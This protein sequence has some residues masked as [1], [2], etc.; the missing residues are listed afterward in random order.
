MWDLPE[1][2][3]R[4]FPSLLALPN[5][6]FEG[7]LV[8]LL[9]L[10][11]VKAL[12]GKLVHSQLGLLL[13]VQDLSG[14]PSIEYSPLYHLAIVILVLVD[15]DWNMFDLCVWVVTYI[16]VGYLRR[17]LHFLKSE[18]ETASTN[19]NYDPRVLKL[20]EFSK[21]WGLL[22][23]WL[24]LVGIVAVQWLFG[25][26]GLR[27][28]TLLLFPLMM[29]TVEGG[30][31][32]LASSAVLQDVL[33][34]FNQNINEIQPTYKIDLAEKIATS[35]VRVWHY[36][37]ISRMFLRVFIR[38]VSIIEYVWVYSVVIAGLASLKNLIVSINKYRSY[39][40]LMRKFDRIFSRTTSAPDQNCTICLTE[41]LNCRQLAVCGHL[42]HYRCL[43]HW[44]QTK[45]ECPICRAPIPLA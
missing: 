29:V 21:Q 16:G 19:V 11:A 8:L 6:T 13:P 41:L 42:F 26:S 39:S 1:E 24:G 4:R 15:I 5:V 30:L 43:F 14:S 25:L 3:A 45:L 9:A 28:I 31:M 34:F 18:R 7:V 22:C 20:L 17:I 2:A 12:L 40:K 33:C 37:H 36:Y 44:M 10:L 32:V 35:T 23:L 27:A 38:K